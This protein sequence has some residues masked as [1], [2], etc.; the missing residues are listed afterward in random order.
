MEVTYTN[1]VLQRIM[2]NIQKSGAAPKQH[3]VAHAV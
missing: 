3:E 2:Q 1:A